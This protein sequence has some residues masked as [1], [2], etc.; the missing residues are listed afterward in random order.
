MLPKIL[1]LCQTREAGSNKLRIDRAKKGGCMGFSGCGHGAEGIS[2]VALLKR[3]K[4][5]TGSFC[6]ES[7]F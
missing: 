4:L 3:E 1:L 6:L 7:H 2:M 5:F